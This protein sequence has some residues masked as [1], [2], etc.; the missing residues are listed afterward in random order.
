MLGLVTVGQDGAGAAGEH[1]LRGKSPDVACRPVPHDPAWHGINLP[2]A[3]GG[4]GFYRL[5]VRNFRGLVP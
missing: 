1:C 2:A 4:A 5:A 3:L